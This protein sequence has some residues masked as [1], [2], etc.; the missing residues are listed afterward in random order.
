MNEL[1]TIQTNRS[2]IINSG[3]VGEFVTTARPSALCRKIKKDRVRG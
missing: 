2:I 1:G 3:D